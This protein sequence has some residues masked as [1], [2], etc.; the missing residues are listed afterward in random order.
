MR[1]PSHSKCV[2]SHTVSSSVISSLLPMNAYSQCRQLPSLIRII[3]FIDVTSKKDTV[4]T[5]LISQLRSTTTFCTPKCWDKVCLHVCTSGKFNKC[6]WSKLVAWD[7]PQLYK[8]LLSF[9]LTIWSLVR[10]IFTINTK[11]AHW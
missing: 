8:Y 3:F 5:V 7:D 11:P 9:Y 10:T 6:Y 2:F 4:I 1:I